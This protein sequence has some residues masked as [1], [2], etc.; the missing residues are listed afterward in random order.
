M[1]KKIILFIFVII[2]LVITTACSTK[3][4]NFNNEILSGNFII[5]N[6]EYNIENLHDQLLENGW[7]LWTADI[8]AETTLQTNQESVAIYYHD[9][10]LIG[11]G[12]I[13]FTI[14]VFYNNPSDIEVNMLDAPVREIL[15]RKPSYGG[16]YPV[17]GIEPKILSD[18]AMAEIK[19]NVKPSRVEPAYIYYYGDESTKV[20]QVRVIFDDEKRMEGI[21]IC[22]FNCR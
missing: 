19:K 1:K 8:N 18:T 20:K 15:I 7:V 5:G 22:M 3:D 13:D 4:T 14:S 21:D 2:F 10:Y 12:I 17:F 6:K 11:S 9:D 16:A